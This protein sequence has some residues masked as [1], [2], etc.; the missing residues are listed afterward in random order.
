MG[1]GRWSRAADGG[2]GW[3]RDGDAGRDEQ[4]GAGEKRFGA[5]RQRRVG[6]YVGYRER[7]VSG[8]R[9]APQ[10]VQYKRPT[11]WLEAGVRVSHAGSRPGCLITTRAPHALAPHR[12][13]A[14]SNMPLVWSH[15][16]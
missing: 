4:L 6:E 3:P 15:A 5:G 2:D 10:A 11:P 12:P 7:S 9:G 16:F 1:G 13:P 14:R 8:E